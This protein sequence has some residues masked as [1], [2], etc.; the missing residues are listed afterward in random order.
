[1]PNLRRPLTRAP[2]RASMAAMTRR[3]VAFAL[4]ALLLALAGCTPD[5][6]DPEPAAKA[7]AQGLQQ[8]N[9]VSAGPVLDANTATENLDAI[10]GDARELDHT[11]TVAG[12]S[13]VEGKP[14]ERTVAL[15]WSWQPVPDAPPATVRT[16]AT[17]TLTDDVWTARW[18]PAWVHPKATDAA[19]FAITRTPAARANI[20]GAGG[21]EIVVPREVIRIGIDKQNLADAV[22]A[23]SAAQGLADALALDDPAGFVAKVAA[24]GPKAYVLALTIRQDQAGKYDLATIRGLPGVLLQGG[25]QFLAPSAEFAR[26]LIGRVGEA[27]KE[28]VDESKGTIAAGDEVGLSGLQRRYDERLRG[29]PGIALDLTVGVATYP[30]FHSE[31]VPGKDL[32]LTLDL[33]LQTLADQVLAGQTSAAGLVAIQPSNGAVLAA[34]TS[35]GS[36]GLATATVGKYPPGSTFKVVTLLALLRAGFT[37]D[38]PVEC[39]PTVTVD[40]REFTNYPGY[41]A[42]AVGTVPL[43]T[44]FA[45]SC[46]TALIAE[47]GTVS[48]QDLADAA[49]ALGLGGDT[50]TGFGWFTGSVPT[51]ATGT[52]HAADLIGQ[53]Q[54]V[55]SP[56]A[57]A[58]VAASVAAGEAVTPVLA[59]VETP[60]PAAPAKPLTAAEAA[61]LAEAMRA[62][63]TE[64]TSTFLQKVPGA[65]VGAKSGTAQ[66]GTGDPLPTHAWMIATQGDLAVAVFV[67]VGDYGTATAG[68]ILEAFLRGVNNP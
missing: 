34:A 65:P 30:V 62:V 31:P 38:S 43:R 63:V 25:K 47:H 52:T 23:E 27:T 9:F 55:V 24:A 37:L 17:L 29:E 46:N 19:T 53:G 3:T 39:T 67:E 4:T 49:A 32:G 35:P 6:P 28:I 14:D 21:A 12:I 18:D 50:E 11:V 44:A 54:V 58:V 42:A 16:T 26:P 60:T 57:M 40:G 48:A 20:T 1:M 64:G 68:P 10:L 59:D 51:D 61:T 41:P 56:M 33:R 5:V 15:D 8:S 13:E 36:N 7:I 45:N 2:A 66:Y 22:A